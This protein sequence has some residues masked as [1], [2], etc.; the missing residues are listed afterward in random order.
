ME[1]ILNL[2][3]VEELR[4]W[5]ENNSTKEKVAWVKSY[6]N[7]ECPKGCLP[8]LEIVEQCL[9]FG[10]IDSTC[11]RIDDALYQRISPRKNTSQWTELNKERVRRL[12]KL[13][14]MK[15]EGRKVLPE[16]NEKKFKIPQDIK[17][18]LKKDKTV[19][20]NFNSF[21][22][23]YQRVRINCIEVYRKRDTEVFNSRL[24]KLVLMTKRNKMY[25][26]WND[27]GKLLDY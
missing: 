10:W 3:N 26:N 19:W 7:K 13:G 18:V 6:R 20:Q 15:E 24:E 17:L 1:N 5:L 4:E 22:P 8:Y 23:L 16:M 27:N 11:K 12:E 9:C 14:L 21:P 2:N 25:G